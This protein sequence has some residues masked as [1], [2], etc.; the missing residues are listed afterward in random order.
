MAR[1][2]IS[3]RE[4]YKENTSPS[5][6]AW[7]PTDSE[8]RRGGSKNCSKLLKEQVSQGIIRSS[9]L[10]VAARTVI[11]MPTFAALS[12]RCLPALGGIYWHQTDSSVYL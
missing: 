11:A 9:P 5:L 7:P 3:L 8:G 1:G 6:I 4:R 2:G 10:R 12:L